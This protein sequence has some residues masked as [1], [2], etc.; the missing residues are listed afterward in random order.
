LKASN[1]C[2]ESGSDDWS[3]GMAEIASLEQRV[4]ELYSEIDVIADELAVALSG[5]A[6]A[7]A[8]GR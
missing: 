1:D 3:Q 4:A 5:A 7:L 2:L 6:D 8:E